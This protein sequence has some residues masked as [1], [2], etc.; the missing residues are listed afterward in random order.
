MTEPSCNQ[1]WTTTHNSANGTI[2]WTIL[3]F[4]RLRNLAKP[5]LTKWQEIIVTQEM[6]QELKT[7]TIRSSTINLSFKSQPQ[8]QCKRLIVAAVWISTSRVNPTVKTNSPATSTSLKTANTFSIYRSSTICK[9]GTQTRKLK[10]WQSGTC[11]TR[12]ETTFLQCPLAGT[13]LASASLWTVIFFAS[14]NLKKKPVLKW[15]ARD[16]SVTIK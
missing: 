10:I 15:V 13:P 1:F 5:P 9:F 8:Q 14:R 7:K 2:W 11:C 6:A 16:E 3:C 4:L 12:T